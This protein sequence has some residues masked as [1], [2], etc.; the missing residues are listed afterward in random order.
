ME[1]GR[2]LG[3]KV[4]VTMFFRLL[5]YDTCARAK[6]P[7]TDNICPAR[8]VTTD[9]RLPFKDIIALPSNERLIMASEFNNKCDSHLSVFVS[10]ISSY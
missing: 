7:A 2:V 6:G 4:V 10:D 1:V 9:S 5:G 3:R 8:K